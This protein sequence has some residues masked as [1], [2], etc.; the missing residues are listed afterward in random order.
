MINRILV[1]LD[2]SERAEL[3]LPYS[4]ME[5]KHHQST[6]VLLRVVP[7]L[8]D[9]IVVVP[10]IID[11]IY[12][13]AKMRAEEYLQKLAAQL[14][15]EGY[16]VETHVLVGSPGQQILDFAENT[17]CDLIVIGSHGTSG[18]VQWRFG[19][20][21]GKVVRSETSMPVVVIST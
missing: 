7:H 13:Q 6:L 1:P 17:K 9:T 19:S 15:A 20:I 18:A 2:G 4:K 3:V 21:A 5:A 16:Q 14:Q 12:D 11:D 10:A 8:K